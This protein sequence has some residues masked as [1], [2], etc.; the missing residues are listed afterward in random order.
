MGKITVLDLDNFYFPDPISAF[1]FR[2]AKTTIENWKPRLDLSHSGASLSARSPAWPGFSL[3]TCFPAAHSDC[4]QHTQF[5]SIFQ[6]QS[7]LA[8]QGRHLGFIPRSPFSVRVPW[9]CKA[10][11]VEI[12]HIRCNAWPLMFSIWIAD[13]LIS[14]CPRRLQEWMQVHLSCQWHVSME[15]CPF[16]TFW[17]LFSAD[18]FRRSRMPF[19]SW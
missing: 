2:Y 14:G 19:W 13:I 9:R 7:T 16:L 10:S 1:F 11:A 15:F 5:L 18:I 3:S 12:L 4:K 8:V 17:V 6:M